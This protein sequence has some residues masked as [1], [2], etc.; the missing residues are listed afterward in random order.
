MVG[1]WGAGGWLGGS[2][3]LTEYE[4]SC[5]LLPDRESSKGS[6]RSWEGEEAWLQRMGRAVGPKE[7]VAKSLGRTRA[8]GAGLTLEGRVIQM[9]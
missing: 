5:G 3:G 6:G 4:S 7:G 8:G 1:A 2:P 9:E